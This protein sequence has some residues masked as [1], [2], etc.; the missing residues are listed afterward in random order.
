M[1]A[2]LYNDTNKMEVKVVQNPRIE[3]TR[4][5][6][7]S[8]TSSDICVSDLHMFDGRTTEGSNLSK[9]VLNQEKNNINVLTDG[10]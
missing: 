1:K 2:V 8:V 5:A 9:V 3:D 10:G 6:T 4:D 7:L